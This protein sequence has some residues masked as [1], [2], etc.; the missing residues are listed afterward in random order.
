MFFPRSPWPPYIP[1]FLPDPEVLVK[2]IRKS[3]DGLKTLREE[4]KKKG[5]EHKQYLEEQK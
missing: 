5:H 2:Y 1:I 4:A 3:A